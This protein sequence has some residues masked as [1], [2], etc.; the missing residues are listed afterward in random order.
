MKHAVH[1]GLRLIELMTV[2]AVIGILAAVAL[3]AFQDHTVRARVAEGI[4]RAC[5]AKLAV[6]AIYSSAAQAPMISA[7]NSLPAAR[8]LVGM[9]AQCL[10]PVQ[11]LLVKQL[12][13]WGNTCPPTAE[14]CET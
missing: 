14:I 2:V 9:V 4:E 8:K 12:R 11:A 1:K 3:P 10:A 7:T 5:A 6:A 13:I